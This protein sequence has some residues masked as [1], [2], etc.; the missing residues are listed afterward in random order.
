MGHKHSE[1]TKRKISQAKT[2]V[3]LPPFTDEHKRKISEALKGRKA[4]WIQKRVQRNFPE[5]YSFGYVL[6]VILGDGSLY[7][8]K[9]PTNDIYV[10][11]LMA[12]DRDFVEGFSHH[13]KQIT[14]RTAKVRSY[15][16]K[17][18]KYFHVS[19]ANK[20]LYQLLS[21]IKHGKDYQRLFALSEEAKK[22]LIAGFIDSEGY[23]LINRER[24]H[25]DIKNT[26]IELLKTLRKILE[27][28]NIFSNLYVRSHRGTFNSK[29]PMGSLYINSFNPVKR[30]RK[31]IH[32]HIARK[33]KA[34]SKVDMLKIVPRRP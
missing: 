27:S 19:P 21:P 30:L 2:G 13:Y 34:L 1:E 17:G 25:I 23:I 15:Y 11:S 33:E 26:D 12:K 31:L 29:L 3:K 10:L 8:G 6:G 4:P 20:G 24:R 22:G 16:R 5:N 7:V 28:Y 9:L 14:G 32:L 18:R